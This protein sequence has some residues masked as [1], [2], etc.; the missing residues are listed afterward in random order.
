MTRY[1]GLGLH[2]RFFEGRKSLPYYS[3]EC[4][5]PGG[6]G[7]RAKLTYDLANSVD[8]EVEFLDLEF[9]VWRGG[10]LVQN[11]NCFCVTAALADW[12]KRNAV[13]GISF[14]DVVVTQGENLNR[15]HPRRSIPEFAELVLPRCAQ[16]WRAN[17][18]SIEKASIP[19]AEMFTG[20]GLPL[21]V[22]GRV[23]KVLSE[24]GVSGLQIEQADAV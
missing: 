11:V 3:V 20:S 21:L 4:E 16:G 14:R 10:E 17:R 19:Q 12:L 5:A 15:F 1:L 18:W 8:L 23:V 9:E 22:T 6:F 2:H 7:P 24:Y 13:I